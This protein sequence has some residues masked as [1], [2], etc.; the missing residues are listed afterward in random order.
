MVQQAYPPNLYAHTRI[1]VSVY[2]SMASGLAIDTSDID[3]AVTG[4]TFNGDRSIHTT[5][6]QILVKKLEQ[7]NCLTYLNFID[8]ATIPVI[9]LK[10]DLQIIREM[11]KPQF[12]KSKQWG[13]VPDNLTSLSLDITFEDMSPTL[14]SDDPYH[15][16]STQINLGIQCISY[17]KKLQHKY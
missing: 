13:P 4:H 8:T 3:L 11:I 16:F 17:I 6:M 5:T 1:N 7:L 15:S 12:R 9:K 14:S 2:G 10:M